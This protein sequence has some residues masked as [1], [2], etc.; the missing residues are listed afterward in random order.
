MFTCDKCGKVDHVVV[1]GYDIGERLLEGVSFHI[2]R[3]EGEFSAKV[4]E[5]HLPYFKRNKI[6]AEEW[7]EEMVSFVEDLDIA[8]CSKC[9]W[10]VAVQEE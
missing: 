9:G 3:E 10:D 5:E 4:A 2:R 7:E 8:A 6:A 1:D